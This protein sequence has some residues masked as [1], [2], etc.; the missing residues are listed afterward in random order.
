M[1]KTDLAK[2]LTELLKGNNIIENADMSKYTSFRAGGK[3]AALVEVENKEQLKAH[4]S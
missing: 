2:R 3:A 1:E 4:R